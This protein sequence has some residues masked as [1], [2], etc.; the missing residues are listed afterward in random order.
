MRSLKIKV[1]LTLVTVFLMYGT[2]DYGIQHYIIYPSFVQLE[3]DEAVKDS[4]RLTEAIKREI[5]HLDGLCHDWAAWDDTYDYVVTPNEEYSES[6]LKLSTFTDNALN[7]IYICDIAGRVVWGRIYDLELKKTIDIGL[8]GDVFPTGHPLV[9]F[10]PSGKKLSEVNNSGIILTD[11]GPMLI[12]SRPILTS[13]NNG[14]VRG[15]VL[16]GRLLN[17][18]MVASLIK[19]TKIQF[20]LSTILPDFRKDADKTTRNLLSG[21]FPHMIKKT[22]HN[23]LQVDTTM[24]DISGIPVILLS[25][26]FTRAISTKGKTTLIYAIGSFISAGITILII[27]MFF[28]HQ[29]VLSPISKLTTHALSIGETGDLSSRLLFH[30]NDEIGTL[31]REFDRMLSQLY[32]VQ[33]KNLEKSF[34]SG[35]VE[36][37]SEVFHNVRNSLSPIVGCIETSRKY[38]NDI[39][40]DEMEKAFNE[41]TNH[42]TYKGN[43][44]DLIAFM[45]LSII[46]MSHSRQEISDNLLE[47][48]N[49][50]RY[51]ETVLNE[52]SK[53]SHSRDGVEK[54]NLEELIRDSVNQLYKEQIESVSIN[55]DLKI[56]PAG[57]ITAHRPTLSQVLVNI[58]TNAIESIHLNQ[59]G[60]NKIDIKVN[61]IMDAGIENIDI[62]ICDTGCGMNSQ[63]LGRIFERRFS[64]KKNGGTGIGLHWCANT[65]S[66]V[67]GR[68]VAESEGIGKGSCF[69][70]LIPIIINP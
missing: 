64:T 63:T 43:A 60:K 39:P 32:D 2:V 54:I 30:R 10:K 25:S 50:A 11:K 19:Q 36:M 34:Y 33:K 38:L 24:S 7:L 15:A 44:K 13:G 40:S 53:W 69:H 42:I 6:N 17:K 66:L 18:A 58:L 28:L 20:T 31:S 29:M 8:P 1:L 14:P 35:M 45:S 5:H 47:L 21:T 65:L 68:I 49:H 16:Q 70:I 59:D 41:L 67:N 62:S 46:I 51:I 55:M 26:W 48:D 4:K 52:Y 9:T 61:T 23:T 22:P 57:S 27:V 37:S 12:A 3:Q 56:P